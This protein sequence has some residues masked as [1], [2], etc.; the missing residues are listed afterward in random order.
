MK[1]MLSALFLW[2]WGVRVCSSGSPV[3]VHCGFRFQQQVCEQIS[4]KTN[5]TINH[6]SSIGPLQAAENS[7]SSPPLRGHQSPESRWQIKLEGFGGQKGFH[8]LAKIS[9]GTNLFPAEKIHVQLDRIIDLLEERVTSIYL[10][11]L[12]IYLEAWPKASKEELVL[13][14]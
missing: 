14:N 2:W 12:T 11:S 1:W 4:D 8:S 9:A 13:S 7:N 10:R 3:H 5:A 6:V